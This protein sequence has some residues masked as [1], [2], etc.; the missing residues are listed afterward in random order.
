MRKGI[1]WFCQIKSESVQILQLVKDRTAVSRS[2][3]IGLSR[4]LTNQFQV[5]ADFRWTKTYQTQ[6][7]TGLPLSVTAN[8]NGTTRYTY[9]PSVRL[10][11]RALRALQFEAEA[12]GEWQNEEIL[13]DQQ[14]FN[15]SDEFYRTKGYFVL[16]GYR[17]D[18]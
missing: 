13:S 18:F 6:S 8:A 11:Y 5:N 16:V 7:S 12:G 10:T 14:A 15:D 1:A 2:I 9:K 3:N 17:L 4:P